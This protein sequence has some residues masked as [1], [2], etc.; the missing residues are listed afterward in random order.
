MYLQISFS[1][2]LK[3]LNAFYFY[4]EHLQ[5]NLRSFVRT[6]AKATS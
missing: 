4:V 1:E 6:R 3:I 5:E 2:T